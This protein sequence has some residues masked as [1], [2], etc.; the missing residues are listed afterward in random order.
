MRGSKR[1]RQT[2]EII[3]IHHRLFKP[4]ARNRVFLLRNTQIIENLFGKP[5]WKLTI[6]LSYQRNPF[7]AR[8][9]IIPNFLRC[10]VC[11]TAYAEFNK[12]SVV[13]KV[14]NFVIYAVVFAIC[15]NSSLRRWF[16]S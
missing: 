4:R 13:M 9:L 11:G 12:S 10:I 5:L 16:E 2:I 3:S 6:I 1:I 7:L 8:N 15:A 14:I